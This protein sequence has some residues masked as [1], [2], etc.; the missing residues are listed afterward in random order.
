[1]IQISPMGSVVNTKVNSVNRRK[2][3]LPRVSR[4]DMD[5]EHK[6]RPSLSRDKP[7]LN[8]GKARSGRGGD[9]EREVG[10]IDEI[11]LPP[12]RA[13]EDPSVGEGLTLHSVSIIQQGEDK[14]ILF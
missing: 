1:M 7:S 5:L 4:G 14:G 9:K 8:G 12:T 13:R 6:Y 11:D 3:L 10:L 2:R